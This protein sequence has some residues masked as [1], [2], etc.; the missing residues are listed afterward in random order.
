MKGNKS[1]E[2]IEFLRSKISGMKPEIEELMIEYALTPEEHQIALEKTRHYCFGGKTPVE[3]PTMFVV[4]SQT[5]G[6]KSSLTARI[7]KENPNTVMIDSDAFKAFNPRKD[8]II[9]KYPTLY[10]YLTRIDGY[11]HRDEIYEEAVAKGYNI[12]MEIAPSTKDKLFCVDIEDLHK[13]GYRVEEDI[14]AVSEIN[15]LISVHERYEG[16]IEAEMDS[17]KLTELKRA[18]DS[19]NSVEII[20]NDALN[21]DYVDV[22]L[23]QRGSSDPEPGKVFMPSP[24]FITSDKSV[25]SQLF[26]QARENDQKKTLLNAEERIKIIKMQMDLRH[27]P[28]DQRAQLS[29]VEEIVSSVEQKYE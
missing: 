18:R 6:G 21:T 1:P 10:G 23:W 13:K 7:L 2:Y 25:M 24:V 27:A 20:L 28:T 4:V 9:R 14:L 16:Q 29:Q 22:N 12:L 11:M 5:G 3:N 17:P 26:K 19:Y 8:E 15:S